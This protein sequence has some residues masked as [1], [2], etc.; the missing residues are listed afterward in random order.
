MS[1]VF[2]VLYSSNDSVIQKKEGMNSMF[3]VIILIENRRMIFLK[4]KFTKCIAFNTDKLENEVERSKVL[5]DSDIM[6]RIVQ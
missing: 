4:N 5:Y 3:I 1:N 2:R 6:G